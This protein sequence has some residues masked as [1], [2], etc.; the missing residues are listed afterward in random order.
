MTWWQ[1]LLLAGIIY[2]SFIVVAGAGYGY[3]LWKLMNGSASDKKEAERLIMN[4]L[5]DKARSFGVSNEEF[6]A[7]MK[8]AKEESEKKS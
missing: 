7:L 4:G 8:K 1:I 5:H 3:R 6:S 2:L